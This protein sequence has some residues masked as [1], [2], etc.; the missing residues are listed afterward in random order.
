MKRKIDSVNPLDWIKSSGFDWAKIV[1]I[2]FFGGIFYNQ[3]SENQ[4][5]TELRFTDFKLSSEKRDDRMEKL[6]DAQN[7]LVN[8]LIEMKGDMKNLNNGVQ[9]I[10]TTLSTTTL[11][12]QG[13]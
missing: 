13:K 12:K 3:F 8:Q 2:V 6:Q 9:D 5:T 11:T 4:K 1:A 7:I 10:K